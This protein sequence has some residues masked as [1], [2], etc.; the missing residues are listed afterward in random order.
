V[1]PIATEINENTFQ[2]MRD[3]GQSDRSS[4]YFGN[5]KND[6]KWEIKESIGQ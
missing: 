1:L 2:P 3:K 6:E 4:Q 5:I